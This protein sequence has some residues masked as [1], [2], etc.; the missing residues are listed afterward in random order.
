LTAL[1]GGIVYPVALILLG[2]FT[3]ADLSLLQKA[4]RKNRA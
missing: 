3:K 2:S 4:L 1:V